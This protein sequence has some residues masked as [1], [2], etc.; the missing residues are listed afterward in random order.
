LIEFKRIGRLG[1]T[2]AGLGLASFS[3][4]CSSN[5]GSTAPVQTEDQKAR[6]KK[7]LEDLSKANDEASK[8]AA[9]NRTG[10]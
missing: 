1:L 3:G 6:E 5:P 4:G 9:A 10:R 7:E 2:L 8:N